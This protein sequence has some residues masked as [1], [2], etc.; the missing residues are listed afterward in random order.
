MLG[1]IPF[2]KIIT[3]SINPLEY[4]VQ[5]EIPEVKGS[6]GFGA[7][8]GLF[9]EFNKQINLTNHKKIECEDID[10]SNGAKEEFNSH[11]Y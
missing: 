9:F 8:G 1:K 11:K 3:I 7:K 10:N 2:V 5:A 6:M 4:S